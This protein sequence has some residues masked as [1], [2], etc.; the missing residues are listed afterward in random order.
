MAFDLVTAKEKLSITDTKQDALI[1][2]TLSQVLVLVEKYCDRKFLFGQEEEHFYWMDGQREIVLERYPIQ[3]VTSVSGVNI[4]FMV[5]HKMGRLEFR[6]GVTTKEAI[7]SYAGGYA[8]L[9]ID[10]E[11]ALWSTFMHVWGLGSGGALGG[12]SRINISGV[13][14]LSYTD[15]SIDQAMGGLIPAES[16][17]IL[18]L[19][20]RWAV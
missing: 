8:T 13:G 11:M 4:D 1:T 7:V 5:N 16:V 18:E 6:R 20:K 15:E 14:S 9:P 19:Y 10:L 12:V 17:S 2:A 3:S